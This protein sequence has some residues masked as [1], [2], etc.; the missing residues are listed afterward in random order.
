MYNMESE[1]LEMW[2]SALAAY[3]GM[4]IHEPKMVNM[5]RQTLKWLFADFESI[6]DSKYFNNPVSWY[7]FIVGMRNLEGHLDRQ[8][9]T[10][11]EIANQIETESSKVKF[12]SFFSDARS[13]FRLKKE[14]DKDTLCERDQGVDPAF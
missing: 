12:T 9:G 10:L 13:F 6:L 8:M 14:R 7:G 1:D 5:H 3:L 2:R 11:L 4:T